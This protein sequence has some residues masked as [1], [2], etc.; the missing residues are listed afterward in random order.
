MSNYENDPP[1][2]NVYLFSSG[3][4]WEFNASRIAGAAGI[5]WIP[6]RSVEELLD[7]SSDDHHYSCVIIDAQHPDMQ[8]DSLHAQLLDAQIDIPIAV[9]VPGDDW[10]ALEQISVPAFHFVLVQPTDAETFVESVR[11]ITGCEKFVHH[12]CDVQ[13]SF[14]RR[15]TLSDR[16]RELLELAV[17][18]APNK[19]I[20]KKLDLHIKTIERI[21]NSAYTKLGVRSTAEMARVLTLAESR[22]FFQ[23]ISVNSQSMHLSDAPRAEPCANGASGLS[24][25]VN[26]GGRS[27]VNPQ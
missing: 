12:Q 18:G 24:E 14:M 16:E 17:A 9:V 21:R 13:R 6:L 11:F 2:P 25:S 26:H 15:E 19:Q 27:A 7:S 23:P 1:E 8:W 20:A 5:A 3:A 4:E 22:E 10:S